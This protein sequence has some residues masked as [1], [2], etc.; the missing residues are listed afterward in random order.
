VKKKAAAKKS[1]TSKVKADVKTVEERYDAPSIEA[2]I[3]IGA[4]A[5]HVEEIVETLGGFD[6][7]EAKLSVFAAQTARFDI[8]AMKQCLENA[9]VRAWL[10]AMDKLA[11]LPKKRNA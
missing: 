10:E 4:L 3:N 5:I 11:L 7:F 1:T 9:K 6:A 2:L 8:A